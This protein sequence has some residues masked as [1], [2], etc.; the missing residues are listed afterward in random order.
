MFSSNLQ[1]ES[2]S[3]IARLQG[4]TCLIRPGF[5]ATTTQ[6]FTETEWNKQT[7][8][9]KTQCWRV[10]FFSFF[11]FI[12]YEC[13]GRDW[14][15]CDLKPLILPVIQRLSCTADCSQGLSLGETIALWLSS[16]C[17]H[18]RD[19]YRRLKYQCFGLRARTH[20]NQSLWERILNFSL[21]P[22]VH[23]SLSNRP[24]FP[25]VSLFIEGWLLFSLFLEQ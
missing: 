4:R 20:G 23:G 17:N 9:A 11:F 6:I 12:S 18:R 19:E 14:G 21:D 1:D 25:S 22:R 10:G 2:L 13:Q 15:G 7:L 5:I 3:V 8:G 24:Q 16:Q